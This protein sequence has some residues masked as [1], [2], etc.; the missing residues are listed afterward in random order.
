[1]TEK[2]IT[3]YRVVDVREKHISSL[4]QLSDLVPMFFCENKHEWFPTHLS[5][6]Q[7]KYFI[8]YEFIVKFSNPLFYVNEQVT[9][10][11]FHNITKMDKFSNVDKFFKKV[12]QSI[13]IDLHNDN[14]ITAIDC[15]DKIQVFT[16]YGLELIADGYDAFFLDNPITKLGE[17]DLSEI[18][19]ASPRTQ[20]ISMKQVENFK[21]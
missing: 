8:T 20:V 5:E 17:V 12:N 10:T 16:E 7:L 1:M 11:K 19:I 18:I 3:V 6:E 15:D 21:G 13:K 4:E 2:T 9:E 14:L